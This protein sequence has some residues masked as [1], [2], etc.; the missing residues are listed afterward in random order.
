MRI[1]KKAIKEAIQSNECL[2]YTGQYTKEWKN[3]P[4]SRLTLI[5]RSLKI[6]F[7]ENTKKVYEI[8]VQKY[9][10]QIWE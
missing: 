1:T 4:M 3:D 9:W 6:D 10:K 8:M 2:T 5:A 7:F